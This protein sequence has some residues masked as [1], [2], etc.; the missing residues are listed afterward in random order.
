MGSS[1]ASDDG[2][3]RQRSAVSRRNL[4][5]GAGLVAASASWP[6]VGA[7]RAFAHGESDGAADGLAGVELPPELGQTGI[8][9]YLDSTGHTLRGV[10]LDYWRAN[11]AGAARL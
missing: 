4:V 9:V 3:G 6:S 1:G 10:M 8:Q 11:G 2:A 5:L 7:D